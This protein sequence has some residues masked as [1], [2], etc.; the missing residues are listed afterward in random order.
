LRFQRSF[1]PRGQGIE[2]Q[3]EITIGADGDE[4]AFRGLQLQLG[5]L[6]HGK[7][8]SLGFA[9]R[10]RGFVRTGYLRS[11]TKHALTMHR[12]RRPS[13]TK[14]AGVDRSGAAGHAQARDKTYRLP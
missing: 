6:R 4:L 11:T 14:V 1:Q 8:N 5:L 13:F 9:V 7:E 3:P 10:V 2:L 12:V